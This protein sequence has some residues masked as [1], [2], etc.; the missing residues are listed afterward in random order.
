MFQEKYTSTTD[1][2]RASFDCACGRHHQTD[3]RTILM[4][5]DAMAGLPAVVAGLPARAGSAAAAGGDGVL[6][7]ADENTWPVA[8]EAVSQI[9]RD[10]GRPVRRLVFPGKPSL[11]PDERAVFRLLDAVEPDTSLLVAIGSGTLNDLTRYVSY[12]TQLPYLVVGTAPSMDG[13]ASNSSAMLVNNL[14]TTINLWGPAAIVA[15]PAYLGSCP[16]IM[17]AAGLGDVLGKF[18]AVCD[19][20]IGHLLNNEYYCADVADL[21]LATAQSSLE[22]APLLARRDPA[23]VIQSMEA[24]LMT[25]ITMSY[26]GNS[27]PASGAEHH[28]SHFWEM[29]FQR[30]GIPAVLHGSKVGLGMIISSALSHQ[31][32]ELR[33]DFEAARRTI[34]A[35]DPAARVADIKAVYQDSAAEILAL[36]QKSGRTDPARALARLAGLEQHWSEVLALVEATVPAPGRIRA[37]IASAHGATRP[38]D[39]GIS[40]ELVEQAVRFAREIRDRYTVLQIYADLGLTEN[41][42]DLVR[43]LFA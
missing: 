22:N 5:D 34:A 41:A 35:A 7:V 2:A 19:W 24:L 23:A 27:R 10:L 39:L 42:V 6:L 37:A 40:P 32:K 43:G 18:G 14:K 31:L 36:D 16:E 33:P 30:M 28:L 12:R 29:A 3:I 13:Y 4:G 26:V 1:Y 11:V 15:I 20:R 9:L 25:G 17:L 8:G 38:S 21:V